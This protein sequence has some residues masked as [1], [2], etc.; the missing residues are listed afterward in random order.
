MSAAV[1]FVWERRAVRPFRA[2]PWWG[3]ALVAVVVA[4]VVGGPALFTRDAFTLDFTNHLWLVYVQEVAI[5]HHLLPTYFISTS[6]T[7][8]DY[9]FFMFYGG[10]LYAVTGAIAALL[11]GAVNTAYVGVIFASIL[12]AYGGLLWLAR[13]L[14]V[15]GW[16]AHA[17]ALTF[18][19]SAYYVTNLYGRGAWPEFVATSALVLM[20]ASGVRLMR[21]ERIELLPAALFVLAAVIFSGSHDITLLLGCL[22]VAALLIGSWLCVGRGWTVPGRRAVAVAGLFALALAVNG[23]YLLP[24]LT[25]ASDT[26]AATASYSWQQSRPFN[27]V[28]ML[29]D[30]LRTAPAQTDSP[31]LFIQMPDWLLVWALGALVVSWRF[32]SRVSR[33]GA[34]GLSALLALLVLAVLSSAVWNAL[35]QTLREMQFPYRL[36]T[37]IALTVSGLVLSGLLGM[38]SAAEL[39]PR[40]RTVLRAALIGATLV[41]A[42]LCVWQ[43]TVPKVAPGPPDYRQRDLV[44][45]SPHTIPLTWYSGPDY[46]DHSQRLV[47]VSG[48]PVNLNPYLVS[49]DRSG[50]VINAPPGRAPFALNIVAGPYAVAVGGGVE[51][52]GR[53]Q[54]NDVVVRRVRPGSGV[55]WV[56]LGPAGGSVTA[57]RWLSVAAVVLLALLLVA[58]MVQRAA[59]WSK[60][61]GRGRGDRQ[62][63]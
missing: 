16:A 18:V 1:S 14:G 27:T 48:P 55:V 41:S 7:G 19:T 32:M 39:P 57:G 8:V 29:F 24:A 42:A 33:R 47:R 15:R 10:T 25:H 20:C 26:L 53:S 43:L 40:S 30:P 31:A 58:A 28:W 38:Q 37:Y 3:D 52:L 36:S 11:G 23:W 5:S 4:L 45:A 59:G 50:Q 2:V 12:A 6:A 9:P 35:P 51:R 54:M 21:A 62:T 60:D 17:P 22:F 34:I 44:F 49:S 61:R 56:T 63:A 46:A 13:Q